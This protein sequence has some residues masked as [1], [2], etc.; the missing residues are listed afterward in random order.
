[1]GPVWQ[2]P[3]QRTVRTAHL[4]VLMKWQIDVNNLE[5]ERSWNTTLHHFRHHSGQRDRNVTTAECNSE[6][7]HTEIL[8]PVDILTTTQSHNMQ[9]HP[10]HSDQKHL[11]DFV[12]A[13]YDFYLY[14][15][16]LTRD[17]AISQLPNLFIDTPRI[18]NVIL[19]LIVWVHSFSKMLPS[20]KFAEDNALVFVILR[21]K[22]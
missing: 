9:Q 7:R 13:S 20:V 5:V 6:T 22:C 1:M 14:F 21:E 8:C 12:T 15:L 4:R 19:L 2:N 3:I 11:P 18:C 16:L 10:T 17:S